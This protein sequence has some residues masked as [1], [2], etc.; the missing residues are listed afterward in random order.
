MEPQAPAT[1]ETFCPH[2][3]LSGSLASFLMNLASLIWH[4]VAIPP[5]GFALMRI[6]PAIQLIHA[7]HAA[8]LIQS[9]LR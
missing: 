6:L 5:M 2:M 4:A 7:G 1:G 8:A 3:S 9:V